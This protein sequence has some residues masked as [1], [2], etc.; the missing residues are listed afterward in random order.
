MLHEHGWPESTRSLCHWCCHCFDGRPY[1]IPVARLQVQVQGDRISV[2]W[3]VHPRI[4][5]RLRG[6]E[7]GKERNVYINELSML[8]GDGANKVSHTAS[9]CAQDIWWR[10]E[11]R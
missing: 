3:N 2:A 1:G 7:M 6:G 9:V 4:F 8:L 5:R 11:H 10:H